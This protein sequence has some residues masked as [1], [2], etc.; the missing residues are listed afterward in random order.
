[1]RDAVAAVALA[2]AVCAPPASA[3][4]AVP[5]PEGYRL[6]DDRAAGPA[7]LRGAT[8]V[9][10]AEVE[11]LAGEAVLIDVLPRPP[12]PKALSEKAVWR[13]RPRSNIPGTIWLPNTG[14]GIL[15]ITVEAY[16]QKNLE[17]LSGGE[18]ARKLVFYCLADCWMSWNA[19]KRALSYG[20]SQVYWYPE[21]TDGWSAAG[22]PLEASEPVPE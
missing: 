12:R 5:E 15:P 18:R 20:Y 4:D 8:V 14:F 22:L 7:T 2:L 13:P 6:Q 16:F 19:A 11:A 9:S 3:Q 21:G 1:M 17:A 10:T